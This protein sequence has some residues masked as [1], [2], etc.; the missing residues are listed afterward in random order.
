MYM[1]STEDSTYRTLM[2]MGV[3]PCLM[4]MLSSEESTHACNIDAN[5]CL[6]V[7]NVGLHAYMLLEIAHM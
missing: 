4:Y 6:S 1:L 7:F 5:R 3:Y 2:L